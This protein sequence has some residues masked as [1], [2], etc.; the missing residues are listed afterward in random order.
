MDSRGSVYEFVKRVSEKDV[1]IKVRL[2]ED[3]GMIYLA[4]ISFHF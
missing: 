1:Y 4:V 2:C 3:E